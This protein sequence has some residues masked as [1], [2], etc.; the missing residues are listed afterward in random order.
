MKKI[1]IVEDASEELQLYS[2]MLKRENFETIEAKNGNEGLEVALRSKP[3]LILLDILMP[4]MDGITMLKE[5]KI[6][7]ATKNIPVIVLTNYSDTQKI[8]EAMENG[9]YGYLVKIDL[10]NGDLVKNIKSALSK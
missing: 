8:A 9:A 5:L 2:D 10:E 4:V 3:D 7:D 6:N 1:L